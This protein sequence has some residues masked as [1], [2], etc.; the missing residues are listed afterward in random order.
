MLI[1]FFV[2]HILS[3]LSILPISIEMQIFCSERCSFYFMHN[4]SI[5]WKLHYTVIFPFILPSYPTKTCWSL[6]KKL[7]PSLELFWLK[8][9]VFSKQNVK[10]FCPKSHNNPVSHRDVVKEILSQISKIF[11]AISVYVVTSSSSSS[12][13]PLLRLTIKCRIGVQSQTQSIEY[14]SSF[15]PEILAYMNRSCT[16]DQS[17]PRC[18]TFLLKHNFE[19][20][21]IE[22]AI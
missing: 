3:H 14:T 12:S 13:R 7:F 18:I 4:I 8:K 9:Y 16:N 20:T 22:S 17:L 6:F 10:G 19:N 1:L 5:F 2:N 15:Y 11:C 21:N